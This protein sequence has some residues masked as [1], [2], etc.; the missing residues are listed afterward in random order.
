VGKTEVIKNNLSPKFS[1]RVKVEYHFQELQEL[2]FHVI[3]VDK[4]GKFDEIG[5]VV[6]TYSSFAQSHC[7]SDLG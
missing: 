6:S 1:T 4:N 5:V 7:H 3:D 2:R